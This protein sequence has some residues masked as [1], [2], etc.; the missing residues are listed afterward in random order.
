MLASS[1][2]MPPNTGRG[3]LGLLGILS[4][5][6]GIIILAYP[7]G[8]VYAA[9]V[10]IAIYALVVGLMDIIVAFYALGKKHEIEKAVKQAA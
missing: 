3:W 7:Y 8:S 10:L 2:D 9:A 1:V 5:A 6:I 4:V